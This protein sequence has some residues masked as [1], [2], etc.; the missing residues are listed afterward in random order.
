MASIELDDKLLVEM[1]RH[2]DGINRIAARR[3]TLFTLR[4]LI[5]GALWEYEERV[6]RNRT[7]AQIGAEAGVARY[8]HRPGDPARW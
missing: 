1:Q 8:E 2:L 6:R 3:N 5:E 4:E 7:I